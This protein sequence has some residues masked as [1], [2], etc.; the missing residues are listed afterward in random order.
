MDSNSNGFYKSSQ[1]RYEETRSSASAFLLL[2]ALGIVVVALHYFGV[3]YIPLHDFA[4][5]VL[6][7]VANIAKKPNGNRVPL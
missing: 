2:G 5:F 4:I 6:L 3:L 1:E 7:W